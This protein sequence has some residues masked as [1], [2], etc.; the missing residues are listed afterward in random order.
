MYWDSRTKVRCTAGLTDDFQV[1]GTPSGIS[2]QP[3]PVCHRN[4]L[5]DMADTKR[6]AMGH[7]VCKRCGV[8]W[9]VVGG[10]GDKAESME[11]VKGRLYKVMVRSEM[12]YGME[13]VTVMIRQERK[14]EVLE[15]K[16]L[17][18]SLG[19]TGMNNVMLFIDLI[20]SCLLFFT[21]HTLQTQHI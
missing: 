3:T 15:M 12:L 19:K 9:R 6:Y 14:M 7:V 5:S 2:T 10:S 21:P 4:G 20:K 8:V 11:Q 16:M 13:E 18:F 17:L 1:T